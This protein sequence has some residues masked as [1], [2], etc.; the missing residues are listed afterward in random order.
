MKA[1]CLTVALV[2]TL[3]AWGRAF[4]MEKRAELSDEEEDLL[5]EEQDPGKRIE[6]YLKLEDARISR[7]DSAR[8][9]RGELNALLSDYVALIEEM[10]NWIQDQYDRR[11]DMREGLREFLA[12]GPQQLDQLRRL[13]PASGVTPPAYRDNLRDAIDDLN[14]AL[15]GSTK[16]FAGQQKLFGELKQE[17]KTD[18]RAAKE[19]V[20]GEKK[21]QKEE[22]K[23]RKRERPKGGTPDQDDN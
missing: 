11:G 7:L 17:Q 1:W 3:P 4:Q 18:A 6:V 21:R 15:D 20:K 9:N 2:V 8:D 23:L 13:E 16:A 14:D 12:R 22:K 5:R 19:R 10:K